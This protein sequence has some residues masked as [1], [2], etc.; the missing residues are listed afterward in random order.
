MADSYDLNVDRF[1]P[2]NHP[3]HLDRISVLSLIEKYWGP[4]KPRQYIR[5][6]ADPT[7]DQICDYPRERV[8]GAIKHSQRL[9]KILSRL[10]G[11]EGKERSQLSSSREVP[12]APTAAS[13]EAK[14][15]TETTKKPKSDDY[16]SKQSANNDVRSEGVQIVESGAVYVSS[17]NLSD[18]TRRHLRLSG[19]A[20]VSSLVRQSAADLRSAHRLSEDQ[21]QEI[22]AALME[23]GL[24]LRPGT[25]SEE[26]QG[27]LAQADAEGPITLKPDPKVSQRQDIKPSRRESGGFYR[28]P[29]SRKAER[30]AGVCKACGV[31]F[32]YDGR[33]G[34]S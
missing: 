25:S 18:H 20:K 28:M 3:P 1:G 6:L 17:L 4:M 12:T 9:A 19:L 15:S 32:G 2:E 27:G 13:A 23:H 24:R 22:E 11:T 30:P 5:D 7:L 31:K 33:C 26:T 10:E 21:I 16:P 29:R 34:C 8:E 14:R